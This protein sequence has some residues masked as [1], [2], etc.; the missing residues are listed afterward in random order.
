MGSNHK[1]SRISRF[2]LSLILPGY[3]D[4]TVLGDYEEIYSRIW[5][6]EGKIKAIGW[7]W[8]QIIKSSIPFLKE[9]IQW[10]TIM[11]TNYIQNGFR[12]LFKN[13]I[14]SLINITGF[15][16][17]IA[18]CFLLFLFIKSEITVDDYNENI[19]NIY[20]VQTFL[21][22]N[23]SEFY[24][25]ATNAVI[26][27]EL[28]ENF[29]EISYAVRFKS[30]GGAVLKY[31]DKEITEFSTQYIEEDV[32]KI[33]SWPL[34]SGDQETA[35]K[36]P[37]SV[38]ISER[39]S[40]RLFGKEN[41]VGKS[42]QIN[43]GTLFKITGLMQNI[44]ENSWFG[45]N[46]I[47]SFKTLET[48]QNLA[49]PIYTGWNNHN[50]RTFALLKP[51][52][53]LKSITDR[54]DKILYERAGDE[55]E[56]NGSS[57]QYLLRSLKDV[58][59]RP[60]NSTNQPIER[61]YIFSIVALIVLV[62]ACIN[63]INLSTARSVKRA[64]EVGI[65]KVLGAFK[66]K[67]I[68][69]FMTESLLT[70]FISFVISILLIYLLIPGLNGITQTDFYN[71]LDKPVFYF[72]IL[73][74]FTIFIGAVSGIY[75]SLVLSNFQ[76]AII[77]SDAKSSG[78]VKS[79]LRSIF[80]VIQFS[81][82]IV[83]IFSTS[84]IINQIDFLKNKDVGYDRENI[85]VT[86]LP[87]NVDRNAAFNTLNNS[88]QKYDEIKSI[89]FSSTVPG[90]NC[91]SNMKQP[92]GFTREQ[93]F[94][95]DEINI[96]ENYFSTYGIDLIKGRNFSKE[97]S[98]D[99]FDAVIINEKMVEM[100]GWDDP[101]GKLFIIPADF[102]IP[103]RKNRKVIGV[104]KNHQKRSLSNPINPLFAICDPTYP[105]TFNDR[106][107]VSI[108]IDGRKTASAIE[109]I[110]KEWKQLYGDEE[111]N[112][113]FM[114]ERFERQFSRYELYRKLISYFTILAILISLLGLV[115]MASFLAESRTKEIGI[116]KVLGA[117]TF[118]IIN[119]FIKDFIKWIVL[120][121]A[122]ALPAGYYFMNGWLNNFQYRS[123]IPVWIYLTSAFIALSFALITIGFQVFKAANAKPVDS[124]KY[125]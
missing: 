72:L 34:I 96:D 109:N 61:V 81:I 123:S 19:D 105:Y 1:I 53:D 95:V 83:L 37:N 40:E 51:N 29:P 5:E 15:S 12:Y 75:P 68:A 99:A 2:I 73:L 26:A 122:I 110:S 25:T 63:F 14:Y 94:L 39:L 91:A 49:S 27:G 10:G 102:K 77:L 56:A 43:G 125:E 92:E 106:R 60:L 112:Y 101:I 30:F 89:S 8:K 114:N 120:S 113:S 44:P 45:I 116:R 84:V 36:E 47:V 48:P 7:F 6:K 46:L 70:S 104:V 38:V 71:L 98:T 64:K 35:L 79:S 119:I 33:F 52:V 117:S 74:F 9:S 17:G 20:N 78:S 4:E 54:M 22:F 13:K 88:L 3:V 97:F 57:K 55:L 69:Q 18:S 31:Q 65:R 41:P 21:K 93:A 28:R 59:L 118:L 16:V 80:L 50:F 86:R 67:L 111:I 66:N 76:P 82:S 107:Y 42:I 108:K 62:L 100:C 32:F 24:G 58:Y 87:G 124:I 90:N 85:L 115:G 11:L 103:G 23:G 121:C